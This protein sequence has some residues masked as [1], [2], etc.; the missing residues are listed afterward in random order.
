MHDL[1]TGETFRIPYER[2]FQDR[3]VANIDIP[4]LG[5]AVATSRKRSSSV[6]ICCGVVN[7]ALHA[8]PV[9]EC[10]MIVSLL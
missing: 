9:K 5:I 3:E 10:F 6:G 4:F 1:Y 8:R 7:T 2:V